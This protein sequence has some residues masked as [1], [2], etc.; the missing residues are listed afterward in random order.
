[1]PTAQHHQTLTSLNRRYLALRSK[2][3][4]ERSM[5]RYPAEMIA[6]CQL[7][8]DAIVQEQSLLTTRSKEVSEP[9]V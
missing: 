7:V 6:E 2:I 9:Y 4:R 5:L 8:R 3:D 1:M